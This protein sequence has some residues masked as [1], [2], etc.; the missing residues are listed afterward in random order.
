M[1]NPNGYGSVTRL[2]GNRRRPYMVRTGMVYDKRT[3]QTKRP[4]LGFYCTEREAL[5]ALAEYNRSPYELSESISFEEVYRLWIERSG[6][7]GETVKAYNCAFRACSELHK[8]AVTSLRTSDHQRVLDR[9]PEKSRSFLSHIKAVFRGVSSYAMG[10]DLPVSD[11]SRFVHIRECTASRGIHRPFTEK[12]IQS[13]WQE[14]P[15]VL[16][17]TILILIYSGWRCRELLETCTVD[18]KRQ[19]MQGGMKTGAG[20]G[21]TVPVHPRIAP[22]LE[23]YG[24]GFPI[25]YSALRRGMREHY[26]HLPHDTRHTFISRLQTAGADHVCIERLAGHSS[27]GVTDRVYTH[28]DINELRKSV[29]KLK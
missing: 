12:E 24:E 7:S 18:A 17:D 26:G 14:E 27:R 3:G 15:S 20:K 1:K 4:V 21:R 22:L 16:R 19:L 11:C 10:C 6:F 23:K 28:K 29:N 13:L 8:R 5:A 25:S 2:S 9:Y